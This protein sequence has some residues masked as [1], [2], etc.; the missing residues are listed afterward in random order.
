MQARSH[1]SA[2]F[3]SLLLLTM[4]TAAMAQMRIKM[5]PTEVIGA[6]KVGQWVKMEGV[7]QRDYSVLTKSI[8][9]LTGDFLESDWSITAVARIVDYR[10]KELKLMRLPIK[11]QADT[12]YENKTGHL[13]GFTDLKE[14]M[15]MEVDG[16]YL[17]DGTFLAVEIEDVSVELVEDP[18]LGGEVEAVGKIEKVDAA[19]QV[20]MLMGIPFKIISETE[21]K[22]AIK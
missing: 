9:V 14:G 6:L 5:S 12:D 16:T 1:V 22:S 4:T 20:V 13:Q 21:L 19:T 10:Q 2:A 11:T 18:K 17:K 8:K 7:V 3:V 15:L